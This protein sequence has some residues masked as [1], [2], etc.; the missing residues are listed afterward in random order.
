MPH[1]KIAAALPFS[2]TGEFQ[3]DSGGDLGFNKFGSNPAFR[4]L[5]LANSFFFGSPS[6]VSKIS[7]YSEIVSRAKRLW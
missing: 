5:I 1:G 3:F 7:E 6:A 4:R 2:G